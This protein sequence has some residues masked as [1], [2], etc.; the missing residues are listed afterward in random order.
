MDEK[1]FLYQ[2]KIQSNRTT[3]L[4]VVL[5]LLFAGLAYWRLNSRSMDNLCIVLFIFAGIFL[6]YSINY[7][8]LIILIFTEKVILHFG[9]FKWAVQIKNIEI[10][11]ADNNLPASMKYGGAGIHFFTAHQ[12]YRISFNFLEYERVVLRLKTPRGPVMD[13][14][15]TTR[16]PHEVIKI[17][18]YHIT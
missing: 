11:E 2:E 3:M 17:I 16:N 15:F 5:T 6:F 18:Q 10:C 8:N 7:R 9:I 12:R 1:N 4:F 14:S 13:V